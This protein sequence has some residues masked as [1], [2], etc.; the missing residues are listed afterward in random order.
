MNPSG[1]PVS[2]RVLAIIVN[3]NKKPF[4][5][6]LLGDLRGLARPPDHVAV[7]DNAS[8]DGSDAMVREKYPDA[9]LLGQS[10]NRGGSGG[11][12]AGMR[13][14]LE[15]GGFDYFWLLDND[16][17][18][19][20][21]ALEALLEV[22][23]ADARVG[24]VGS[25]IAVLNNA[26]RTQEVGARIDWPHCTLLKVGTEE[27]D[28]NANT[29]GKARV[30]EVEYVSACSL[31]ARVAA[32]E[33]VGIW[34]EDYFIYFDDVE[35]GIRFGRA[36][37]K[38]KATTGSVVEHESYNDRRLSQ[39]P[40]M[41]YQAQRNGMYFFHAFCPP[42]YRR[43]AL[44]F[45]FQRVLAD[46]V[47]YRSTGRPDLAR[48]FQTALGDFFRSRRGKY[49]SDFKVVSRENDPAKNKGDSAFEAI[50]QRHGRILLIAYANPDGIRA[51]VARLK[52]LLPHH[53]VEILVP[54]EVREL[55]HFTR[56]GLMRKPT[57]TRSDRRTLAAWALGRYDGV[58]RPESVARFAFELR[59]PASI[60]V[61][62]KGGARIIRNGAG[63][64]WRELLLRALVRVGAW[65]LTA[66]ALAKPRPRVDYFTWN[67]T[68]SAQKNH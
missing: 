14:G 6:R 2:P 44:C 43:R 17:V 28:N 5:D 49:P 40:A 21:G 27:Q 42:E 31:L 29:V 1:S 53:E 9:T 20:P 64:Y 13:W 15:Q 3:W 22:A 11:F 24:L 48:S 47:H 12:N 30:Y 61:N 65:G 4:L 16:V 8:S 36:G 10:V 37:W 62:D 26:D 59:F 56:D 32:I 66:L 25:R 63:V 55:D 33:Q 50:P 52:T 35:W 68:A 19:H 41:H 46:I 60:L 7:V 45:T 51:A 18:V 34:D 67:R 58:A 38:I 54:E 23:E 57:R 39:S